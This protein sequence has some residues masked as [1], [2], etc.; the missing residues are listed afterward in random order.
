MK[1]SKVITQLL[2]FIG[3]LVVVNMISEQLFLRLDFTADKRYTLSTATKD[4]LED[5]DDVITVTAYFT[6]DLPPQLQPE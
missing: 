6:K 5:L 3:I 4:I 1:R 2:I